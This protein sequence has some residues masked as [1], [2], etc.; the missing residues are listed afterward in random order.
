LDHWLTAGFA[1]ETFH[2]EVS[3][4]CTA[5]QAS[6]VGAFQQPGMLLGG[7]SYVDLDFS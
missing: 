7:H 6:L 4:Q 3:R 1:I 5:L 2:N